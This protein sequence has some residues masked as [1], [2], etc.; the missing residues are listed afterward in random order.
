MLVH[1]MLGSRTSN[2]D[3]DEKD[4]DDGRRT[5]MKDPLSNDVDC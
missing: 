2:D 5:M 4:D 1:V 3:D